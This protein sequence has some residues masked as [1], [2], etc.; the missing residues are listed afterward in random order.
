MPSPP[1]FSPRRA[2][3]PDA[4]TRLLADLVARWWQIVAEENRARTAA[5][6]QTC[7]S[8]SGS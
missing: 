5:A 4:E 7:K 1:P 8:I 3:L 2:P 6:R